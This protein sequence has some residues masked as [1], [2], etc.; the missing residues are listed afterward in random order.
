[1]EGIYC[2]F[3][4]GDDPKIA[5]VVGLGDVRVQAIRCNK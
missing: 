5:L 3:I 1:M 4:L 2:F